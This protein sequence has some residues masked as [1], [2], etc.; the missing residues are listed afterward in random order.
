MRRPHKIDGTDDNTG[1][2]DSNADITDAIT[3]GNNDVGNDDTDENNTD[4]QES[5]N[6]DTA[7]HNND[8]ADTAHYDDGSCDNIGDNIVAADTLMMIWNN[9]DDKK[10]ANADDNYDIGDGDDFA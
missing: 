4:F 7:D 6:D 9:D 3:L 5:A 2:T 1:D 8:K 10:Y